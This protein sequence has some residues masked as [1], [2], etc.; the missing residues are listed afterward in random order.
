DQSRFRSVGIRGK[1][2]QRIGAVATYAFAAHLVDR[3]DNGGTLDTTACISP[4]GMRRAAFFA[5]ARPMVIT[6]GIA[7]AGNGRLIAFHRREL[8]LLR[9]HAGQ[10]RVEQLC[11]PTRFLAR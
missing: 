6:V 8:S 5:V 3:A 1:F 2:F 7:A 9:D 11:G 4:W 10:C